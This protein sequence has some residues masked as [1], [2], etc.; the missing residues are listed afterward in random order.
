MRRVY[1][2]K[3]TR[4][5]GKAGRKTKE[6]RAS[7]SP[8]KRKGGEK[9]GDVLSFYN[10]KK[11]DLTPSIHTKKSNISH[12]S[13]PELTVSNFTSTPSRGPTPLQILIANL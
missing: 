7:S 4:A 5:R 10:V 9:T 6:W 11:I 3:K 12:F 2:K 1:G 13:G 8:F